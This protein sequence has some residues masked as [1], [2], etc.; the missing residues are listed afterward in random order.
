MDRT[1]KQAGVCKGGDETGTVYLKLEHVNEI[2]LQNKFQPLLFVLFHWFKYINHSDRLQK[3]REWPIC[4][5]YSLVFISW[6]PTCQVIKDPSLYL[7]LS[8]DKYMHL[9]SHIMD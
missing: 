1:M 2:R 4:P 5:S 6:F 7:L 9:C 3:F 8:L